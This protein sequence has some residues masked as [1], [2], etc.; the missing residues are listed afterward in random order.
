[1]KAISITNYNTKRIRQITLG[2]ILVFFLLVGC[3]KYLEIAPPSNSINMGNVY[4]ENSTASAVLTSIYARMS[5]TFLSAGPT[6]L[7]LFPEMSADNL[8]LYATDLSYTQY[9][10]NSLAPNNPINFW[11][12]FYTII[13]TSNAAIEGLN[14]TKRLNGVVKTHLL[15]EAYFIRAFCYF[16]LVNLYG[17]VP[18]V[19]TTTFNTNIQLTRTPIQVIYGQIL[20]D[21]IAAKALL[22]NRYLDATL[23]TETQDRV[24]PNLSAVN[25]LMARVQLYLR[26]Y[27]AA[28]AAA[29]DVIN[30]GTIYSTSIELTQVFL[31]NSKETVW[32]LQPV[33][34]NLNTD[35]GNMFFLPSGGPTGNSTINPVYASKQLMES[36]EI[37]DLRKKVWTG[38][39]TVMPLGKTYSFPSK[40]KIKSGSG[41]VSEYPIVLRLSEQ[42][43][44]RAEA[45]IMSNNVAAGVEDLNVLRIRAIDNSLNPTDRLKLLSTSMSKDDAIK[46]VA[47]E[48]QVELFTEWGHRWFDLKRTGK[49]DEVMTVVSPLK[50][51]EP[52]DSNKALYPIPFTEINSAP[53]LKQ[54]P[55]YTN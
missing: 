34:L 55:G 44:I 7:S 31:K 35:E 27:T 5:G 18:L 54:N 49:I 12:Q 42:Y 38:N 51:G 21:L 32:A 52:W 24:R 16:Y 11:S 45:R 53:Q 20:D 41:P 22:D 37:G 46:A 4:N 25:A 23:L 3:K 8:T 2:G 19:T 47:H 6:S 29:S 40:Y 36:F 50:G 13:Y 48:R 14:E 33:K 30:Q 26:N 10:Q 9:Y 28:E 15:G 1:M 17:D 39:V 43:L